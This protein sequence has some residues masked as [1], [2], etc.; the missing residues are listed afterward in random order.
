MIR[1]LDPVFASLKS[2]IAILKGDD[3]YLNEG[4]DMYLRELF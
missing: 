1:S 3:I 2:Q 4:D